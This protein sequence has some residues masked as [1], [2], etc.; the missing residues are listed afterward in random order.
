M[1]SFIIQDFKFYVPVS[2]GGAPTFAHFDTG[3][4]GNMLVESVARGLEEIESRIM[5]GGMGRQE[6]RQVR[7]GRLELLGKSFD[8]E[9]AVV[10]DGEDYFGDVPFDVSL[11][12]GADVLLAAP[13]IL[14]FKRLWMGF[15]EKPLKK[16]LARF[17]LDVAAG[18]PF[19]PMQHKRN[20]LSAIFDTGASFSILNAR[21]VE[22]LGLKVEQVYALEVQD[23]AGGK[24]H[25]PIYRVDGIGVGDV[26][27]GKCEAFVVSL[28][29]IEQRLERRIDFVLGANAM[30]TSSLVWVL[31]RAQNALFISERDV[32]VYAESR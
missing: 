14:D 12:L 22:E 11:T 21:H 9:T 24:G 16:N 15:A 4:S 13:L 10:F 29:P 1:E 6:V 17:P 31:D 3:S 8:D 19:I 25:I 23:P 18:L 32:D 30:L 27:L 20:E 28:E 26:D 7:L 5:Q 2:I